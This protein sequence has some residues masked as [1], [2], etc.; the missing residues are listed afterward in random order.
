MGIENKRRG[1]VKIRGETETVDKKENTLFSLGR[2]ERRGSMCVVCVCVCVCACVCVCVCVLG[3]GGVQESL[4]D[5]PS[6]LPLIVEAEMGG[7][8]SPIPW[9]PGALHWTL[10]V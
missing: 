9:Q 3:S 8:R 7:H 6:A 2:E 4:P 1:E 10:G 5:F